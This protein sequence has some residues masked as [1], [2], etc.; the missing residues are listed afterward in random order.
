M[1]LPI[2]LRNP[3]TNLT[4][5]AF[6]GFSW[7]TLFFGPFPAL[8]RGDLVTFLMVCAVE[9]VVACFTFGLGAWVFS[10]AWAFYYNEYHAR[11]L[12][13]KG[14]LVEADIAAKVEAQAEAASKRDTELADA[15][16]RGVALAL[17]QRE[18][19]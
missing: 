11:K 16:S 8:F 15:I 14:Y 19:R 2:A 3:E 7:T 18:G 17:A 4:E 6:R 10:L 13:A 9:F 1:A 5:R 12:V